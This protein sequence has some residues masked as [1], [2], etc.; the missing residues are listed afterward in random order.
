MRPLPVSL[1][2]A[3]ETHALGQRLASVLS[4]GDLL[5]LTGPL[6]AGKT[7]LTQGIGAGLGVRGAVTS[8][9]FVLARTHAGPVP[10]VHADAYRLRAAGPA[11]VELD[12]LDLD[13]GI[14]DSVT[15]VEWGEGLAEPLAEARLDV[16]LDRPE[17]ER[18]VAV[19]MPHG[20]RWSAFSGGP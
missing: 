3:E 20:R 2:S 10:L 13:A 12:D 19:V 1:A 16:R 4:P 17:D 6:G 9:T 18:R 8:P 5:V 14:A 7:T 15:V 11:Q